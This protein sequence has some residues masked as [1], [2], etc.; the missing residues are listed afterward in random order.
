MSQGKVKDID[1]A[2]LGAGIAGVSAAI[3][4]KRAGL[5][6][7]IFE[8]GA[9]GG[10]LYLMEQVDNYVGLNLG[11]K[12]RDLAQ[13]L[14]EAL[15]DLNIDVIN[16]E[17]IRLEAD[18]KRNILT[19][20]TKEC[21][22]KAKCA[23]IASGA[24]FKKLAVKGED[25][26]LGKGVSYC[27]VCDGFFF[28]GKN[29]AVV[30]GGNTA[31]EEALY[32][33]SIAR[34]VI[35]I[36]RKPQ[37][38]ALDYLQKELAKKNNIELVLDSEVGEIKGSKLLEEVVVENIQSNKKQNISLEGLFI[39]IGV[40]PNTNLLSNIVTLDE[41]GFII[42]DEY[43]KT[44]SDFIWAAGDCANGRFA[45]LLPLPQKGQLPP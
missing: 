24:S 26:F 2:I 17:V 43:M 33:S 30:G 37:L 3:Y 38:R 45:S 16:E 32:L 31:V 19:V 44:S 5:E 12:G 9:V 25:E 39:A 42:T 21:V 27:A 29:V 36:H 15:C 13:K 28:K 35:L 41:G 8:G 1:L 22:Y 11:T 23:L 6:F 34:K 4:T 14:N 10:Q 20:Y 7:C 18:K 40:K